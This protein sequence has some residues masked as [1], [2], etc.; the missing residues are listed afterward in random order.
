MRCKGTITPLHKGTMRKATEWEKV[1]VRLVKDWNVEEIRALYRAGGWWK[2]EWDLRHIRDVI[3]GSFAFAVA[4]DPETGHAVAMGRLISDGAS[5]AY[6]Q[7]LIVLPEYRR[8]GIGNEILET[9]VS[10]CTGNGILWI[11]LIA[12]PGTDNFYIPAG[13]TRMEGY[14]PMLFT[15]KGKGGDVHA[16]KE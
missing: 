11:G 12:E 10:F 6:I 15:G 7:D 13:F 9:L 2:E 1:E 5:D 8:L 3:S 4:I 16:H 14:I